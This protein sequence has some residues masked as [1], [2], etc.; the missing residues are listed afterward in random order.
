MG[1]RFPHHDAAAM[2]SFQSSRPFTEY[3]GFQKFEALVI[4]YFH[5]DD[6][7]GN[8]EIN[9]PMADGIPSLSISS[10]PSRKCLVPVLLNQTRKKKRSMAIDILYNLKYTID[11]NIRKENP[12]ITPRS[13]MSARQVFRL[14]TGYLGI[15]RHPKTTNLL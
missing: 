12:S 10:F 14:Q 2:R 1:S 5:V 11:T 7:I 9:K 4:L 3:V 15:P 13:C 8:G 6:H